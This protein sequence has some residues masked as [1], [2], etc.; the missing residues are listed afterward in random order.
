MHIGKGVEKKQTYNFFPMVLQILALESGSLWTSDQMAA[1]LVSLLQDTSQSIRSHHKITIDW[2]MQV[3]QKNVN[4]DGIRST[5][6]TF[7]YPIY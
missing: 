2:T 7:S 4:S 3:V 1:P 5:S 6:N